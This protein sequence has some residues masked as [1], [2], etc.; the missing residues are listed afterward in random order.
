VVDRHDAQAHAMAQPADPEAV[1]EALKET[2]D[3]REASGESEGA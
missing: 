2:R 1:M 3:G